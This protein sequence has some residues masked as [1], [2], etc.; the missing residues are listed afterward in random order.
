MNFTFVHASDLHLDSP[1]K[2]LRRRLPEDLSDLAINSSLSALERLADLC[3]GEAV[4]FLLLAGDVF[5]LDSPSLRAQVQLRTFFSRLDEAGIRTFRVAGNHDPLE[6]SWADIDHPRSVH[7]FSDR[8]EVCKLEIDGTN[9]EIRGLSHPT[10]R[11]AEDPLPGFGRKSP[12]LGTFRIGLLHTDVD[13]SVGDRYAPSRLGDLQSSG[14]DY[15]ALGHAHHRAVLNEENPTIIY[16]GTTQGRHFGESGA[17]GCYLVRVEDGRVLPSFRPLDSIRWEE[18]VVSLDPDTSSE[19]ILLERTS[20]ALD[21]VLTASGGRPLVVR[22][23]FEGQTPLSGRFGN[24]DEK[25]DLLHTIRDILPDAPRCW[26][27]SVRWGARP[28]L[29]LE[30]LAERADVVG[31]VHRSRLDVE[32]ALANDDP[33]GV[34]ADLRDSVEELLRSEPKIGR[35]LGRTTPEDLA[36]L[37][38]R[39]EDLLQRLIAEEGWL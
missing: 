18:V 4:D 24:A 13:G 32:R 38:D 15:W 39:S 8:V 37:L 11:F 31:D 3:I 2:G 29:N 34:A 22:L 12:H 35:W 5:D 17:R 20:A 6:G 21:D 16:S 33:D 9:V 30:N 36:D 19:D 27:D 7:F 25:E 10:T 26:V 28:L 1:F 23:T 14:E